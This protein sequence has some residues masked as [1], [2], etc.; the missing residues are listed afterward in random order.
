MLSFKIISDN[1]NFSPLFSILK[2][3]FPAT[4]RT[5]TLMDLNMGI[6]YLW[7]S[8]QIRL[9]L[10]LNMS[11]TTFSYIGN[12]KL[13]LFHSF[14]D[15]QMIS[16]VHSNLAEYNF[17]LFLEDLSFDYFEKNQVHLINRFITLEGQP[18]LNRNLHFR[19]FCSFW[20]NPIMRCNFS[21]YI[22]SSSKDL[23]SSFIVEHYVSHLD[24]CIFIILCILVHISVKSI[25]FFT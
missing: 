15:W 14:S 21:W 1:W 8:F 22:I 5:L 19:I 23:S 16:F 11:K 2:E 6:Q 10:R 20:F 4:S 18:S 7:G 24:S 25:W 17:V 3:L 12:N 9:W 13:F